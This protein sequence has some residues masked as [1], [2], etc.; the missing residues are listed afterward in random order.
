MILKNSQNRIYCINKVKGILEGSSS[1]LLAN[2]GLTGLKTV[3]RSN[4]KTN[5]LKD[6]FLQ[7]LWMSPNVPFD[8]IG[9]VSLQYSGLSEEREPYKKLQITIES[10][11]ILQWVHFGLYA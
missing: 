5:F 1:L 7:S 2:S 9:E 4:I 6:L 11:L 10:N 8:F 3:N